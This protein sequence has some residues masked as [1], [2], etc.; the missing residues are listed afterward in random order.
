MQTVPLQPVPAQITRTVLG[1]QNCQIRVAQKGDFMY[2][3]LNSNG[4][5]IVT[6][7]I[8]RDA[9]PLLARAYTGFS[10]NFV[11]IDTQGSDDPGFDG[12]GSRFNLVY[13]TTEED[14]LIQG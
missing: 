1:G 13:L 12:V 2:F 9:V 6:S 3:D 8:I 7:V 10:G 4:A 5:E 14:A 11:F